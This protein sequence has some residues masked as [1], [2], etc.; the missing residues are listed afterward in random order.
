MEITN[1]PVLVT[2]ELRDDVYNSRM[3]A[4][5]IARLFHSKRLYYDP[6]IQRGLLDATKIDRWA[7]NLLA[8]DAILGTITLNF[9]TDTTTVEGVVHSGTQVSPTDD[10]HLAYDG[11]ASVPDGW[12]RVNAIVKAVAAAGR[13]AEFDVTRQISVQVWNVPAEVE[14]AIFY[15]RNQEGKKADASRSKALY[16]VNIG[17]KI[18]IEFKRRSPHLGDVNIETIRNWV[19]TKN[20]RLTAF[21]TLSV[22]LFGSVVGYRRRPHG[23]DC[24]VAHRVLGRAGGSPPRSRSAL[25]RRAPKGSS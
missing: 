17:Q 3:T 8:G 7:E 13:G 6:E 11:E 25:D 16:Q 19:R 14:A 21:N 23:Q 12:H 18:A 20:P 4:S 22:P 10:G 15:W 2:Q 24:P 9:R 1:D 5:A